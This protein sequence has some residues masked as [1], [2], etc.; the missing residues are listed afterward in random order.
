M[1]VLYILKP[2]LRVRNLEASLIETKS[3]LWV[4]C[5]EFE[6]SKKYAKKETSIIH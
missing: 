5:F 2:F 4:K 1:L 6:L 3:V